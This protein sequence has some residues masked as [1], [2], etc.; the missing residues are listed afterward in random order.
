MWNF[1]IPSAPVMEIGGSMEWLKKV[2]DFLE[3]FT[4]EGTEFFDRDLLKIHW[5]FTIERTGH[6]LR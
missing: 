2:G 4:P 6:H 1:G 3:T 5:N